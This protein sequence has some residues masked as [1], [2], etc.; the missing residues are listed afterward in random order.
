MSAFRDISVF[1][2]GCNRGIGL[3]CVKH[4][5]QLAE[6]PK[7]LFATCRSLKAESA[8]ELKELAAKHHNLHLLEFD[9]TNASQL[10]SAVEEVEK[11]LGNAGLNLLINNAGIYDRKGNAYGEK[12]STLDEAT[13]EL[14]MKVFETNSVAPLMIA[15]AFLPLIRRSASDKTSS[16]QPRAAIVNISSDD[17]SIEL[18]GTGGFYQYKCSKVALN[19]ITKCLS[20]ELANDEITVVCVD[21]GWI[22]TDMGG[23]SAPLTLPD[24]IPSLIKLIG[25]LN[26]S[27]SGSFLQYNGTVLPW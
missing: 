11:K 8:R 22:K 15:K 16:C 19:M 3:A 17:G 14:M 4:I 6:T 13:A 7:H 10:T 26:Q 23:R 12:S 2:T 24:A 18:N 20:L 25:S 1:I 9:V 27:M 5:L 21:P